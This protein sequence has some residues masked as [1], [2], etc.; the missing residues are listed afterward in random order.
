MALAI[1]DRV[2]NSY[3]RTGNAISRLLFEEN[4]NCVGSN[5]KER[6]G[7]WPDFFSRFL[8]YSRSRISHDFCS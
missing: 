4:A 1:C 2:P 7:V 6:F 5:R 8:S 3:T